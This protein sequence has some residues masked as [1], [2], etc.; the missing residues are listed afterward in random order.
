MNKKLKKEFLEFVQQQNLSNKTYKYYLKW[1]KKSLQSQQTLCDKPYY[2]KDPSLTVIGIGDLH[3]D[4]CALLTILKMTGIISAKVEASTPVSS[5]TWRPDKQNLVIVQTGDIMDSKRNAEFPS[6]RK[7][8]QSIV[9]I[10]ELI[11]HLNGQAKSQGYKGRFYTL[12]GN[13]E[14][15]N[16]QGSNHYQHRVEHEELLKKYRSPSIK[17]VTAV[18]SDFTRKLACR[19][20]GAILIINDT[21]FVHGGVS[22]KFMKMIQGKFNKKLPLK[23]I[24]LVV[25]ETLL[26][27]VSGES[28]DAAENQILNLV[29][30][31][32]GLLWYRGLGYNDYDNQKACKAAR[33][34]F[35]EDCGLRNIVIGHTVQKPFITGV[36]C[37]EERGGACPLRKSLRIFRID[38]GMSLAFDLRQKE[39]SYIQCLVLDFANKQIYVQYLKSSGAIRRLIWSEDQGKFVKI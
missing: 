34:V 6:E 32:D 5:I 4:Y 28:L 22:P 33:F 14:M 39:K 11:D 36:K 23:F 24:T 38:A 19:T 1:V 18:G 29:N 3:G 37:D 15:M 8:C 35:K 17:E 2:I 10:F 12:I 25:N 27:Y 31:R 7:S 9:K 16:F 21:V 26:K 30:N 13:H 20:S